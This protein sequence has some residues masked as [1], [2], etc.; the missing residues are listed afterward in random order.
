VSRRR[1]RCD[2]G[3]GDFGGG[4]VVA[5]AA[6]KGWPG[7]A[8]TDA[9]LGTGTHMKNT[10]TATSA[11]QRK[12]AA[13]RAAFVFAVAGAGRES[14]AGEQ[15]AERQGRRLWTGDWAAVSHNSRSRG[16]VWVTDW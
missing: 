3:E 9:G 12:M 14:S 10:H 7:V 11:G 2:G 15:A 6:A 1:R 4:V 13:D 8:L 16:L 5:G